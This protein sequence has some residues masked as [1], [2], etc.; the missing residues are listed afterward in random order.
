LEFKEIMDYV[1]NNKKEYLEKE[2]ADNKKSSDENKKENQ[3]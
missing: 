3:K 2:L 1:E